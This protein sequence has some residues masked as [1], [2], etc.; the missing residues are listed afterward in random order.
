MLSTYRTY[1][2]TVKFLKY[3]FNKKLLG[4]VTLLI[5]YTK[6]NLNLTHYS[7]TK[8]NLNLTERERERERESYALFKAKYINK[9]KST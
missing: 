5:F 8:C 7:Y 2:S 1:N 9:L 3:K 4:G 6:C